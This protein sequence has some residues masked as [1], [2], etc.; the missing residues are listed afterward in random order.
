MEASHCANPLD[1]I[2][3][4]F[5]AK[6]TKDQGDRMLFKYPFVEKYSNSP[7]RWSPSG[8]PLALTI[9]DED[10]IS[11][12]RFRHQDTLIS[13]DSKL[14]GITDEK[15]AFYLKPK[16]CGKRFE[17]K[18]SDVKFVGLPIIVEKPSNIVPFPM[19]D[20]DDATD[21]SE[22]QFY[23]VV[24]AIRSA[25]PESVVDSLYV[26]SD[27][28]A[29]A[30]YDQELRNGYL[31]KQAKLMIDAHEEVQEMPEDHSESPYYLVLNNSSLACSLKNVYEQVCRQGSL[32]FY[33]NNQALVSCCLAH[34]IHTNTASSIVDKMKLYRCI[35]L[36]S[37]YHAILLLKN[38]TEL[39]QGLPIDSCPMLIRLINN[40]SPLKSLRKTANE[41]DI[42][43]RHLHKLAGHMLY[44]GM[45]TIIIP[46]AKNNVYCISPIAKL[47]DKSV[48]KQ[49]YEK[50][51]R[52]NFNA[53]L[54]MFNL[55]LSVGEFVDMAALRT[56][57]K[58]ERTRI[59]AWLLKHRLLI[60]RHMYVMLKPS[61][62][63]Y[64]VPQSTTAPASAQPNESQLASTVV[65]PPVESQAQSTAALSTGQSVNP[66][67]IA[68]TNSTSTSSNN[69]KLKKDQNNLSRHCTSE[70]NQDGTAGNTKSTE[71]ESLQPHGAQAMEGDTQAAAK[72]QRDPSI[73]PGKPGDLREC[74]DGRGD[75]ASTKRQSSVPK[76]SVPFEEVTFDVN[77][78]RSIGISVPDEFS[79]GC[80]RKPLSDEQVKQ[81]L[82]RYL[83]KTQHQHVTSMVGTKIDSK[84]LNLFAK[85]V[86]FFHGRHH[87]EHMM[88]SLDLRRSEI[89]DVIDEM[90][91]LLITCY[92][93]DEMTALHV[94]P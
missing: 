78:L 70:P 51:P 57:D 19:P 29:G 8:N 77:F 4:F 63:S 54:A 34:K 74:S 83:T 47:N 62:P 25:A 9:I 88:H 59:V 41:L 32:T 35:E 53:I 1:P 14:I 33:L 80:L 84:T 64:P 31:G 37:P 76:R 50:F 38:K 26:V 24:W 58:A 60:Q 67:A 2:C 23:H 15:L 6:G 48:N 46:M 12:T 72:G 69:D 79:I 56:D 30:L 71:S 21:G 3:L 17:M 16:I 52:E 92:H 89:M 28:L 66:N 7:A 11:R 44:W 42:P 27:D 40:T 10:I 55:P 86:Q 68:G 91:S 75:D 13:N 85:L 43:R 22:I 61:L 45:A 93:E 49:F 90:K 5:V 87:I 73:D 94:N 39:V 36:I 18:I 82:S 65:I 20:A 81:N